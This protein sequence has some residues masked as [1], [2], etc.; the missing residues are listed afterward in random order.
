M[1]RGACGVPHWAIGLCAAASLVPHVCWAGTTGKISGRVID[2]AQKPV[3]WVQVLVPAQRLSV[4]TNAEGEY[5]ILNVPPGTYEV[6]FRHVSYKQLSVREVLVSADQSARVDASLVESTVVQLEE[7]VVTAKRPPV[8]LNLTSSQTTVTREEIEQLPVQQLD[9][10]VNLQAGVVEGH[11]RGGRLGEV[12]YQVDGISVNNAF[13]NK[14][15]F[16]LDRSL[17]QEVQVI[18][19]TFD[20]EYGQA[21]SGVVNAVLR[22]G[23]DKFQ[24][25]AEGYTGGFAYSE[26]Q[27]S[28]QN[29]FDPV[30]IWSLQGTA[31]G[32]LPIPNTVFLG[33]LRRASTDDYFLG[34]RRFAPSDSSDFENKEFVGTGDGEEV[35][36]AFHREW[37]GA[38]K[39]TNTSLENS[40][41]DYQ[42]LFDFAEGRQKDFAFRL[43]PDGLTR[44]EIVAICH[45]PD[46]TKTFD[47]N[48]YLELNLRQNYTK[49]TDFAYEDVYDKRY[50][51]AGPA[52]GDDEYELGAYVQGVSFDRFYQRTNAWILK[53]SYVNQLTSHHLLKGGVE[54]NFPDVS[55]GTPGFLVF[56]SEGGTETLKRFYDQPPDFPAIQHYRPFI[57]AAYAQDTMEWE[58]FNVRAGLRM[59]Y[60]DARSTVPSDLS[61]PANSIQG[62]PESVP[63]ETSAK[64]A[65]SPRLGISY[66]IEDWASLHFAYG[67]F[68]QFPPIGEIFNNANYDVLANL[69]AGG[70]D[71]GVLGNPDVSPERTVQYEFGYKQVLNADMGLDVTTFYKDIRDLLGVE[72]VSTYNGAEYARLTNVDLGDVIGV[73]VAFDARRIGRASIG[74]DYTWQQALGNSSDPRETATRASAG[75]DPQP[76]IVPFVW[77]QRH[78]VNLTA[79]I[80]LPNAYSAS[81]ILRA[82]SGQPYTPVL[83]SGFNSGLETNSGRKPIG[84]TLDLRAEK[85]LGNRFG[86]QM[87]VFARAF[88]LFDTRYYNGFVFDSTGSPYYSRFPETD[89]VTLADPNR[90]FPPRR[91]EIGLRLGGGEG[92]RL[93]GGGES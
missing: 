91:L 48:S 51:E 20:A 14:N 41:F 60:F 45:G 79:S 44:Q 32:P 35:P 85:N 18:S 25:S 89:R 29:S 4:N 83:D 80:D 92:F 66:P 47:K 49:F 38:G 82:A 40:K 13:D 10:L 72:F 37:S 15:A 28:A 23:T 6:V 58:D 36:L 42:F 84:F 33:S 76:R 17:L 43:N 46:W 68:R 9:D 55:F 88:N 26:D 30:G 86:P 53:S 69:Q 5:T 34:V 87:A 22:Q 70:V 90:F 62:A 21:M 8:D 67:H 1:N 52:V 3:P 75:E 63:V 59:D 81:A 50:D 39:L 24:W 31:S 54:L 93:G 7:I 56:T 71:Y 64:V 78:T 27:R 11:F 73:T 65:M 12:Q 61:N 2:A 16:T 19:G 57:G 77:D 74:F